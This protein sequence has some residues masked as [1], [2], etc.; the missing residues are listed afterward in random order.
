MLAEAGGE[1]P[2]AAAELG[3]ERAD[4]HARRPSPAAA[5]RRAAGRAAA[6]R[7]GAGAAAARR[8]AR[9]APPSRARRPAAPPA[10]PRRARAPRRGRRPARRAARRAERPAAHGPRTACRSTWTPRARRLE[11]RQRGP[12]VDGRDERAEPL[13]R[14]RRTGAPRLTI[15]LTRSCGSSVR[16]HRRR[17]ALLVARVAQD[18]AAEQR[19]RRALVHA[20]HHRRAS[21]PAAS[22]AAPAAPAASRARCFVAHQTGDRAVAWSSNGP[23]APPE[24]LRGRLVH[25]RQDG[26]HRAVDPDVDRPQLGL[27]P[28]RRGR[29]RR[30]VGASSG[31]ASARPPSR[32][33]SRAAA[34]SRAGSRAMSATASPRR[35]KA[36]A[37][38]RPMPADAPVMAS[39]GLHRRLR[40][41]AAHDPRDRRDVHRLRRRRTSS[42]S[43][44]ARSRARWARLARTRRPWALRVTPPDGPRT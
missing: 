23:W 37:V 18:G 26:G 25:R 34:S 28:L 42:S 6:R 17:G 14:R 40:G 33:I 35:A 30:R 39:R 13:A 29:D 4:A 11:A 5:P 15:R 19:M 22:T 21:K 44:T 41:R 36:R 27:D 31:T 32:S 1:V 8:A 24:L 38:A 12:V 43:R 7:A 16:T 20:S 2:A 10:P 3:G 9:S